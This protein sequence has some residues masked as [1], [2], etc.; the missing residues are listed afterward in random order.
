MRRFR[1][2]RGRCFRELGI[3][4]YHYNPLA[5]GL[6]S[7]KYGGIDDQLKDTGRFGAQSPI[8]CAGARV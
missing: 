1:D 8:R 3:R 5:G 2:A 6:L 4:S 7:G